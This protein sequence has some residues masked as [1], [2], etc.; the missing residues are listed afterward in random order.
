MITINVTQQRETR[1]LSEKIAALD[2]EKLLVQ[3]MTSNTLCN[4]LLVDNYPDLGVAP[5]IG[6]IRRGGRWNTGSSTGVFTIDLS[7]STSFAHPPFGFHCVI[8]P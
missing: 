7:S 6:A 1:A 3:T 8:I 4:R 2:V 5:A